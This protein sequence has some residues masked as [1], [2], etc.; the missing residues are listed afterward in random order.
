MSVYPVDYDLIRHETQYQMPNHCLALKS[1]N[2]SSDFETMISVFGGKLKRNLLEIR[3]C[4][5]AIKFEEK[6][7]FILFSNI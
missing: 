6:N 5:K 2:Q 7:P 4:E 3:Y 1:L